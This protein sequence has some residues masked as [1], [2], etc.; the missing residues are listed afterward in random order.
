MELEIG[1]V[2]YLLSSKKKKKISSLFSINPLISNEAF[3][4][5]RF[6]KTHERYVDIF[7]LTMR[8]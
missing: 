5:Q 7:K 3:S 2:N 6:L 1:Q 8:N 4:A